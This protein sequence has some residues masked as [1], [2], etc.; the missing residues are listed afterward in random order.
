[1][2]HVVRVRT[3]LRDTDQLKLD[4]VNILSSKKQ[5]SLVRI[6]R[7]VRPIPVHNFHVIAFLWIAAYSG[8]KPVAVRSRT[9]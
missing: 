3:H 1:M 7:I 5:A 8:G 2:K 4:N 9:T 6:F